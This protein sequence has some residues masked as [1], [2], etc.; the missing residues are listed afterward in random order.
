MIGDSPAPQTTPLDASRLALAEAGGLAVQI[1][2]AEVLVAAPD[3]P[4]LLSRASGVLALHGLDV[5]SASIATHAGTAVNRFSVQPRFGKL[6]EASLLQSD[7]RLALAES[8]DLGPRLVAKEQAYGRDRSALLSPP[9]RVLW[10]D[11]EATDA[12]V[13]E[14]R[15]ADAI[16]LLHR[17]TTALERCGLDIRSALVSTLGAS[18]VDA[19]YLTAAD[20]SAV[21][22]VGDREGITSAVLA[23]AAP[24]GH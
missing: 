16:G 24:A 15:A 21:I 20:G 10:F 6:P 11:A 23:A 18:V 17:V 9:P 8:L 5:R 4:G 7:L 1:E 19:F 2:G 22:P 14:L 13:M 3:A 12:T